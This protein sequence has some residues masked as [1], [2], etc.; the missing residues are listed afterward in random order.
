ML[1]EGP[2][3]PPCAPE[4]PHH[5]RTRPSMRSWV[6]V[7][8]ASKIEADEAVAVAS[9]IPIDRAEYMRAG[10]V[11]GLEYLEH[12][13]RTGRDVVA[14]TAATVAAVARARLE[15]VPLTSLMMLVLG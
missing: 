10:E 13:R 5:A 7:V 11:I 8:Y 12:E 6:S 3:N 15:M 4:L 1:Q 14:M 2:H 9:I